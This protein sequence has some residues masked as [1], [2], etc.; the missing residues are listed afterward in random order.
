MI[1]ELYKQ[2]VMVELQLLLVAAGEDCI[3]QR[4]YE[5]VIEH[6]KGIRVCHEEKASA[7][8]CADKIMELIGE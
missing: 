7:R 6:D 4:S 2:E 1:Y 8:S 3:V 5:L